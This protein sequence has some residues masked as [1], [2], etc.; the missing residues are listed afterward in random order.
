MFKSINLGSD[1]KGNEYRDV[2]YLLCDEFMV[3]PN[4]NYPPGATTKLGG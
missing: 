3:L 2:K 4:E 1:L